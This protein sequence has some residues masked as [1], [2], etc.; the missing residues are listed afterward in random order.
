L[1]VVT[2]NARE[3]DA[4]RI[5]TPSGI[6]TLARQRRGRH[7]ELHRRHAVAVVVLERRDAAIVYS[8]EGSKAPEID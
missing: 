3:A 7:G 1:R 6:D 2:V 8:V 5:S 4:S